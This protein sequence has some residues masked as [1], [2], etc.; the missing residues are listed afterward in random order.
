[1]TRYT[2]R[3]TAA[4]VGRRVSIRRWIDDETGGFVPSDVVGRLVAW[5]HGVLRV[6]TKRDEEVAVLERDVLAAK[7]IPDRPERRARSDP[8]APHP[9]APRDDAGDPRND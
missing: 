8:P 7:P 9:A 2:N 3:L 5:E 1:V 6:V 4:D